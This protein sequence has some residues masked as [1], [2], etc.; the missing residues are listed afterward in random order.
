MVPK[1][2][3][4]KSVVFFFLRAQ[5]DQS[6][7]PQNHPPG[8]LTP[9]TAFPGLQFLARVAF[10]SSQLMDRAVANFA[11]SVSNDDPRYFEA[12]AIFLTELILSKR[13]N[14]TFISS[15]ANDLHSNPVLP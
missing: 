7:A 14:C 6:I 3:L 2:N 10:K 1:I 15:G 11:G 8:Q 13:L 5:F 12:E 4:G 9:E